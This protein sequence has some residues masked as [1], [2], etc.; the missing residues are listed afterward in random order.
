MALQPFTPMLGSLLMGITIVQKSDLTKKKPHAKKALILGGGAI[1]GASFKVG[2]LK[3]F[4]D[5]LV[6]FQIS[7]FD[8]FLGISSGSLLAAALIGGLTPEEMFKSFEGTSKKFSKLR[9]IHFYYPNWKEMALRPLSYA[10][11]AMSWLPGVALRLASRLPSQASDLQKMFHEF[12]KHPSLNLYEQLW[13][14]VEATALSDHPFP[15]LMELLPS[16]IF[17]NVYIEQYMRDNIRRNHLTND[18]KTAAK[19]RKKKLYISAMSLDGAKEVT[20]GP[21]EVSTVS[22]SKAVQAS[23]AMPGFYKPVKIGDDYYVDGIVPRTANIDLL[24]SKG[25]KLIICYNPFRPYENKN[26]L[27]SKMHSLTEEGIIGVLNQIFRTF[28]HSRLHASLN[29]FKKNPDFDGDI[30]LIEPRADDATFF[31]MNPFMLGHQIRATRMGFESVR[32]SIDEH[33]PLI[34]K[35]MG[36]YGIEMSREK[37]ESEYRELHFGKDPFKTTRILEKHR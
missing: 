27:K 31:S 26:F 18:F 34:S 16:G 21:D 15:S 2:G 3:A 23:T 5:Y 25:A 8:L 17:D 32:N 36:S 4:N 24:V 6:N 37:V 11:R 14:M 20:F 9:P 7:D 22:I 35:I 29:A 33:Y 1:T 28:F 10:W 12:V 19:L 30:I 13:G